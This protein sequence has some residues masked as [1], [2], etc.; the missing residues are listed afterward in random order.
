MPIINR[1]LMLCDA[2]EYLPDDN[3]LTDLLISNIINNIIDVQIPDGQ[4][5][6]IDDDL[7]YSED[8]CKTLKAS[9][10]LNKAKFSVDGAALRKEKVDGVEIEQSQAAARFAWDD[11]VKALSSICPYLP[12]GG[13]AAPRGRGIVINPSSKFVVDGCP[14]ESTMYF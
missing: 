9:A 10:L 4:T 6:P 7:Y 2:K 12:G 14:T 5:V 3:A 11:Y 1:N 8:L 13:Y